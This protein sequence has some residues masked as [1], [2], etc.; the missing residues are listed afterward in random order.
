MEPEQRRS[1]DHTVVFRALW[2]MLCTDDRRALR[3]CCSA[4]RDAVDAQTGIVEGRGESPVLCPATCARLHDVHTLTLGS[5]ACL[6]RMLLVAHGPEAGAVFPHLQSLRLHLGAAA[7]AQQTTRPSPTPLAGSPTVVMAGCL[8]TNADASHRQMSAP[9][10]ARRRHPL[11]A[12]LLLPLLTRVARGARAE[13]PS[14]ECTPAEARAQA[15]TSIWV[16]TAGEVIH[17]RMAPDL[18][19]PAAVAEV[20]AGGAEAG[21]VTEAAEVPA[22]GVFPRLQSLRLHLGAA[23]IESPAD[24]DAIASAAPWLTHLSLDL[25]ARAIALPQHMAGVLS[26]CSKLEDLEMRAFDEARPGTSGSVRSEGLSKIANMDALAAGT[27]LRRLQ[28]PW[29]LNL[30]TLLP[31]GALMNLQGL[32]ISSCRAVFNLAPLATVVNLQ[33]LNMSS[34]IAVSDVAPLAAMVNLQTLNISWCHRVSDLAPLATL[35]N[36]QSLE[37]SYCTAVSDLA[38]LAALVK[39]QSL[40]MKSCLRV[41]SLTPLAAMV[42][43]RSLDMSWFSAVSDLAPLAAMVNLQSLGMAWCRAVSDLAPLSIL[44]KLQSLNMSYCD[45]VSDLA[46]LTAMANLQS[47]DISNCYAVSD[48]APL[49]AMANLQS[50][51]MS[52][53]DDVSD[54]VPL[55]GMV[56]LQTL[57]LFYFFLCSCAWLERDAMQHEHSEE[58][59]ATPLDHPVV[60]RAL[61]PMLCTDERLALR[62]CCSAMCDAVDALAGSVEGQGDSPV[63]CPATCARLHDVHTLTLGSMACLRRMLLV[64]HG[65]AAGAAFPRL[66]SLR[67]HLPW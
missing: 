55:T 67:L 12:L 22:G 65:P 19:L 26:A 15:D 64:A 47:L 8:K 24:Y 44:V 31:L 43:L 9:E 42:N 60:L 5:M 17:R 61:W 56:N 16:L 37:V 23:A 45:A 58:P 4:M 59:V 40:M 2:P 35:M 1:L 13:S 38:P 36:L 3:Q 49:A 33:S 51:N 21:G 52:W 18:V 14:A 48:L 11:P 62:Q 50:L 66:Q 46:P 25:P 6:R 32:N 30:T 54:L 27:Q 7:R 10:G 57:D 28:L 53:C 63:L 20:V 29:C 39:L 34:C 41:S